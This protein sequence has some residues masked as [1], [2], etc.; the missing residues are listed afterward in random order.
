ML[1]YLDLHTRLSSLEGQKESLTTISSKS[2][3]EVSRDL[4]SLTERATPAVV[5]IVAIEDVDF[6]RTNPWYFW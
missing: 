2:L 4:V 3:D 6:Y 5:S 1:G